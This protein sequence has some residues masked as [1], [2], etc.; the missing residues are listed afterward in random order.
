[1]EVTDAEF[2]IVGSQPDRRVKALDSF[3]GVTVVGEVEKFRPYYQKAAVNVVPLMTGGGIIVKTLNG[4]ASGRP[5][6]TSPAGNSGT[7]ARSGVH[8]LIVDGGP[9]EFANSVQHVLTN[10]ALWK[11]LAKDGR[12]Y[13]EQNFDWSTIIQEFESFLEYMTQKRE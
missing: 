2:I 12:A 4:L 11:R 8:L 13:I 6:V 1:V 9:D 5:T 10:D 7:G 3:P